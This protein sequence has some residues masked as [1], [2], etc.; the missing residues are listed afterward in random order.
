MIDRLAGLGH[1]SVVGGDDDDRDVGDLGAAS[2]HL[3]ERLVAGRVDEGER[4]AVGGDG[5]V[6]ADV[7]SDAAGLGFDDVGAT[8]G[9]EQR[10][11][12]VINV[13]EHGDDRRTGD[14]V[15]VVFLD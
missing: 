9:V 15:G 2:A 3:G 4:A 12:A 8:D 11:L 5:L 1:E 14:G 6:G 7:L 13:T 10:G